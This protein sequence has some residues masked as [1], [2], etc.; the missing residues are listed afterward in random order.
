MIHV[1]HIAL[2]VLK[3]STNK[4]TEQISQSSVAPDQ[5]DDH[6]NSVECQSEKTGQMVKKQ[7]IQEKI[8]YDDLD[9]RGDKEKCNLVR[10]N[11]SK[12]RRFSRIKFCF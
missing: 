8:T 7:R 3:A 12:V 9:T 2:Q 10:L 1:S 5:K 11:L 4:N 6:S